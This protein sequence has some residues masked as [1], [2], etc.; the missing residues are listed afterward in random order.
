MVTCAG[1]IVTMRQKHAI[2]RLVGLK[3][4]RKEQPCN[5]S[6]LERIFRADT[7]GR[8]ELTEQIVLFVVQEGT[9]IVLMTMKE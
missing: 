5:M 7:S 3:N 1:I 9:F 4:V 2:L 6:L 8:A